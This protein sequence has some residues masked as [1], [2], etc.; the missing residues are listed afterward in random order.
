MSSDNLDLLGECI[1]AR[2]AH[3]QCLKLCAALDRV[4]GILASGE[5]NETK[6]PTDEDLQVAC[7][8]AESSLMHV[9]ILA[10]AFSTLGTDAELGH[11]CSSRLIRQFWG[12]WMRTQ[13][14]N[15]KQQLRKQCVAAIPNVLKQLASL[16]REHELFQRFLSDVKNQ[17]CHDED[18]LDFLRRH[19]DGNTEDQVSVLLLHDNGVCAKLAGVALILRASERKAR[20]FINEF[21]L[22]KQ[23]S[24]GQHGA[25]L[26][27]IRAVVTCCRQAN[28]QFAEKIPKKFAEQGQFFQTREPP[29]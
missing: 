11:L 20:R 19:L 9:E 17:R 5:L 13:V 1:L 2:I 6:R 14:T 23:A 7:E 16:T 3:A 18:V 10:S 8:A 26:Y 29:T 25:R 4:R 27:D 12:R 24:I 21:D 28:V 15:V 22:G